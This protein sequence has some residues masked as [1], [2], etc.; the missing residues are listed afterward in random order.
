VL[1]A[2]SGF[3]VQLWS[4]P[5][6]KHLAT[7]RGHRWCI[8]GLAFSPDGELLASIGRDSEIRLWEVATGQLRLLFSVNPQGNGLNGA[9]FSADGRTLASGGNTGPGLWNLA[10]GRVVLPIA[11]KHRLFGAPMFS[12]DGN[13]LVLGGRSAGSTPVPV[14]IFQA[15]S[16]EEIEAAERA[17]RQSP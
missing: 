4:V 13:T 2:G 3:D 9:A 15:P 17:E 11:R 6:L 1:A 10:S 16:L 12:P 7:L 8:N 14:E 5:E